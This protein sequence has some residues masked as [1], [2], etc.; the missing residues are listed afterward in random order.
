V[1]DPGPHGALFQSAVD[2]Y[3]P[4]WRS[5][6][7]IGQNEE[8]FPDSTDHV[9]KLVDMF[10]DPALVP[11]GKNGQPTIRGLGGGGGDVGGGRYN[12][13]TYLRERGDANI[14]TVTDLVEKANF[15][16]DPILQNRKRNLLGTDSAMTLSTAT[17]LQDRFTVQT[18]VHQVLAELDLDAVIYPTG[19]IPPGILTNPEEP[20]RNDRSPGLWTYVNSRGFPAM[21][22]PAGFT[23]RVYDRVRDVS[24]PDS[25][26]LVG[27]VPAKLPVGI[28]FLGAPFSEPMLFRIAAAYEA[29]TRHRVPPPDFG[30]LSET[31]SS[32]TRT[33]R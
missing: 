14:R 23:T 9:S 28:D 6:L 2:K 22:V 17:V 1:V 7:F 32:S 11:H 19:N 10:F 3:T 27:P 15:W 26:R 33:A 5:Q 18:I 12:L 8:L 30:P 25:T 21:T 29:R 16:D 20:T 13:S 4:V 31:N 24:A